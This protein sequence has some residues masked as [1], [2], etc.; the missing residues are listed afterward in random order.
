MTYCGE[1][2]DSVTEQKNPPEM[3]KHQTI[4]YCLSTSNM[5]IVKRQQVSYSPAVP[6]GLFFMFSKI[7]FGFA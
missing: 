5:R 4:S 1:Q 7:Y 2:I 6:V 3:D